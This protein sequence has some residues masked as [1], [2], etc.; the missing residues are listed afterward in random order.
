MPVIQ[1]STILQLFKT[2]Q[3]GRVPQLIESSVCCPRIKPE[4]CEPNDAVHS[5]ISIAGNEFV[6]AGDVAVDASSTTGLTVEGNTVLSAGPTD[7]GEA[8]RTR[9]CSEVRVECNTFSTEGARQ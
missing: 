6:L 3:A 4:N 2:K 5:N 7:A 1:A 8:I 9:G